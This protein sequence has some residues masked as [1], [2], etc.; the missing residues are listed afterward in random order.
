MRPPIMIF[1]CCRR[2]PNAASGHCAE[3]LCDHRVILSVEP[4]VGFE[5][6]KANDPPVSG[7]GPS[8]SGGGQGDGGGEGREGGVEGCGSYCLNREGRQDRQGGL[9]PQAAD[10]NA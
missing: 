1:A 4:N 6:A 7:D 2:Y 9:G 10:R 8:H 3:A 5:P